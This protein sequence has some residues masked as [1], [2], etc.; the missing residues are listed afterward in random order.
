[1]LGIQAETIILGILRTV[2]GAWLGEV[3]SYSTTKDVF[4]NLG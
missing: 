3:I 4:L 1:M 2:N